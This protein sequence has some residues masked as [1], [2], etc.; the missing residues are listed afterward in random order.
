MTSF[1]RRS[2]HGK[3]AGKLP[4]WAVVLICAVCAVLV[5]VI[6]GNLLKLWLDDEVYA[7]LT[8][9]NGTESAQ[10]QAEIKVPTLNA[11]PFIP[12]ESIRDA[13]AKTQLSLSINTPAGDVNYTSPVALYQQKNCLRESTL[14]ENVEALN[15]FGTYVSGVF[16]PQALKQ[17]G[18]DLRHAAAV[19]DGAL[20][21]EFLQAGG[22]EILAVGLP[23]ASEGLESILAYLEALRQSVGNAPLGVAVPLAVA[24]GAYG[25]L[26]LEELLTVC[27]FLVLDMTGAILS[28]PS[29]DEEG[30]SAEVKAALGQIGLYR[31][32]YGMRILLLDTQTVW[33]DTLTK[34]EQNNVQVITT[35]E[36]PA[37]AG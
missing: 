10:T 20:V 19:E 5:A 34:L 30:I 6:L 13:A 36:D 37:P 11:T 26:L 31:S 4:V 17:Q 7:N 1:R 15:T 29:V 14:A 12:G 23:F 25:G 24:E 22:K 21:R 33:I 16:Y 2:H 35:P 3:H 18:Q 9:G 32:S 27:D 8:K 28:D